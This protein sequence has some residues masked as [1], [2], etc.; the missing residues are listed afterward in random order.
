MKTAD[1]KI[2]QNKVQYDLDK[3]IPKITVLSSRN[4]GEF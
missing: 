3:E 2:K 4:V 1:N